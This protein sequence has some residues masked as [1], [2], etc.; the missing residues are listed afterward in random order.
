MAPQLVQ[1]LDLA[2]QL[3]LDRDLADLPALVDLLERNYFTLLSKGDRNPDDSAVRYITKFDV[4]DLADRRHKLEP[5]AS[6]EPTFGEKLDVAG[7]ADLAHRMGERRL[8]ILPTLESW[9]RDYE[10][11][12]LDL[13]VEH[14]DPVLDGTGTVTTAAG[15]LRRHLEWIVGQPGVEQLRDEVHDI[16]RALARLGITLAP[17]DHSATLNAEQIADAYPVSRATVYRWWNEGRLTDVGKVD[18]KR[19]FVVHEIKALIDEPPWDRQ[20]RTLTLDE[21]TTTF[22]VDAEPRD[23]GGSTHA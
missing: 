10:A 23:E 11:T 1:W 4:L 5:A 15:W 14:D 2:D 20:V 13:M 6:T 12:M 9:L 7:E 22:G 3:Q 19:V 17:A 18:R 16:V 8:G 21:I